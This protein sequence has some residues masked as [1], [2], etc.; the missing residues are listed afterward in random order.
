MSRFG[1]VLCSIITL[2]MF[3]PNT[4]TSVEAQ[5]CATYSDSAWFWERRG[6]GTVEDCFEGQAGDVVNISCVGC[7]SLIVYNPT[8]NQIL[9]GGGQLTLPADGTYRLEMDYRFQVRVSPSEECRDVIIGGSGGN[10]NIER[11]CDFVPGYID[12]IEGVVTLNLSRVSSNSNAPS[13]TQSDTIGGTQDNS[14]SSEPVIP[15][16]ADD[17]SGISIPNLNLS[18]IVDHRLFTP[19]IFFT[20]I[21][22]GG[23]IFLV[24]LTKRKLGRGLIL[25]L[26]FFGAGLAVVMVFD[27][28]GR[29][30]VLNVAVEAD[31]M[32]MAD[33][34]DFRPNHNLLDVSDFS[35]LI[36]SSTPGSSI[37]IDAFNS[38]I[39]G[40]SCHS[41]RRID[42]SGSI[43][44][45]RGQNI[46]ISDDGDQIVYLR[47]SNISTSEEEDNNSRLV[48]YNQGSGTTDLDY[49]PAYVNLS[50]DGRYILFQPLGQSDLRVVDFDGDDPT[51]V[52]DDFDLISDDL[53]WSPDS[54]WIALRSQ[55][56]L[57]VIDVD[58]GNSQVLGAIE[59]RGNMLNFSEMPDVRTFPYGWSPDGT[60]IA[61]VHEDR[62]LLVVDIE[63]DE[64]EQMH[65]N[66][67]FE[68]WSPDSREVFFSVSDDS[69]DQGYHLA[70]VRSGETR[71][72]G[73]FSTHANAGWTGNDD[74]LFIIT[75][76]FV[77]R[78]TPTLSII[79]RTSLEV[80]ATLEGVDFVTPIRFFSG[81]SVLIPISSRVGNGFGSVVNTLSSTTQYVVFSWEDNPSLYRVEVG[82]NVGQIFYAD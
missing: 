13:D 34:V 23:V 1:L 14:E 33:T 21:L 67:R 79:D 45:G 7:D 8:G 55:G 25:M 46:D 63:T 68:A 17:D 60:R 19:S 41:L 48:T 22:L 4:S 51:T 43:S 76:P 31:V 57:R 81:E 58:S 24:N 16:V 71:F 47:C 26:V 39:G 32:E 78:I 30:K 64:T 28:L 61:F 59:S 50:P 49:T 42:S 2:L 20:L 11:Q 6:A 36:V 3:S 53:I 10:A 38:G 35:E 80:I 52:Y 44:I 70:D 82:H 29:D 12:P 9:N 66:G 65:P 69:D 5:S 62:G 37:G 18:I 72:V 73:R 40:A 74:H 77:S 54:A 15:T 56:T 75:N 27:P